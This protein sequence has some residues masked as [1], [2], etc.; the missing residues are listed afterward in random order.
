MI[1][2]HHLQMLCCELIKYEFSEC[3]GPLHKHEGHKRRPS[4]H[5]SA[6][7]VFASGTRKY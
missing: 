2:S 7:I 3:L 4:G 5:G 6:E 1:N